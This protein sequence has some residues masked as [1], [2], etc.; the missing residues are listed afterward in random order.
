MK[1]M[2]KY[3]GLPSARSEGPIKKSADEPSRPC[4]KKTGL[5]QEF[6]QEA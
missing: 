6:L 4:C 3:S 2:F 1:Y 5:P